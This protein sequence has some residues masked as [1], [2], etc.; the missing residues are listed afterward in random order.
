MTKGI[1]TSEFWLTLACIIGVFAL[2]GFGKY[3]VEQVQGL[4]PMFV[5]IMGYTLGRG[6]VKSRIPTE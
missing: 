1:Q 3:T 2:V 6:W 4:W 5:T